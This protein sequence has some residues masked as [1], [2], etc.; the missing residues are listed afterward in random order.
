MKVNVDFDGSRKELAFVGK[1]VQGVLQR[2]YQHL[3]KISA[4]RDLM[5]IGKRK[6]SRQH[7]RVM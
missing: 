2:H 4:N 3:G 5:P 1:R 7:V 6:L